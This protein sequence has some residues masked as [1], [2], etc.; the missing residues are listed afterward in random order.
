MVPFK[1]T[2]SLKQYMRGKP[3]PWGIK[4]FLL[5]CGESGLIYDLVLFQGANTEIDE[6]TKKHLGFGGAVVMKL[7]ENVESQ[8]HFCTSI[9][10]SRHLI[11]FTH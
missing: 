5:V 7:T 10:N 3:S 1:G 6:M 4:T 9:T 11:Y 2:F 8:R